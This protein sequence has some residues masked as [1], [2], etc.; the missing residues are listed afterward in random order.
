MPSEEWIVY[1]H[2]S[3]SKK[4]YI[5]ITHQKPELRWRDGKGYQYNLH[6][7][8]A[9]QKYGWENFDHEIVAEGL[10]EE[11]AT[12]LEKELV[13]TY[14]SAKKQN[15]YNVAEGGHV[16]SEESR[17]KI[18]RSRIERGFVPWSKGKHLSAE[19]RAKISNALKGKKRTYP[20]TELESE[21]RRR[22]KIGALNPNYGKPMEITKK[23]MLI[24]LNSKAVV[25]ITGNKE[26]VHKSATEAGRTLGIFPGNITRVCKRQRKTAG[27]YQWKYA[28]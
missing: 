28:E 12:A 22:S 5:G 2:T 13:A 4:V 11:E 27:G 7:W 23:Q 9:I 24:D 20:L 3:P 15:G 6:F 19:T 21:H 18:S 14:K 25:Q 16:L 10:T 8:K 26:I 1:K 17:R